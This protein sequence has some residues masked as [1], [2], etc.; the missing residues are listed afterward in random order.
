MAD[1]IGKQT[2]ALKDP[3][4]VLG[5]AAVGGRKEGEGP[6]GAVFDKI[7]PDSRCGEKTWEKAESK[8]QEVAGE[9]AL[10]KAGF[11][12]GD[13]D[14][15]LAGDLLNQCVASAYGARGDGVPYLGLYGACSTYA[16][17]NGIGAILVENAA[18]RVLI[19]VSSHFCTAE[20][21]YRYP[22]EYG[23]QRPPSAQWTATAAG[24][25]VLG[26]EGGP[27]YIRAV[28]FGTVEDYGITDLNNMGAAM[29]PAAAKTLAAF[30]RDTETKPND[31]SGIFTG[32]LG[33]VGANLLR[34]LLE[35]E[36]ISLGENYHDCGLLLFDREKQQVEAGAS[37]CGCS[38]AV[39]SCLVLPKLQKGELSDVLF[40]STGALM[41][42]LSIQQGESIP[43][44]AHL[45]Y[46]SSRRK[47]SIL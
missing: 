25:A 23:G 39:A 38:A 14:L 7:F 22:L 44:V 3:P 37:G 43:G 30:F 9:K 19:T 41:S 40:L 42:P 34:E 18:D 29:A 32:D 13:M 35:R 1:R 47:G 12:M 28:T 10:Q 2:F 17:A 31:F 16:E 26:K 6:L 11:C 5:F 33:F 15:H 4:A 27:P 20:R 24:A 8:M 36:G 21:Q 45:I 46:Y